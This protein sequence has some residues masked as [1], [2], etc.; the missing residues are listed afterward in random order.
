MRTNSLVLFKC[1]RR[2]HADHQFV[3]FTRVF[4]TFLIYMPPQ[5]DDNM[6]SLSAA[7][8]LDF[9]LLAQVLRLDQS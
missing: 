2:F 4:L 8:K 1:L 5:H 3:H 6:S 7:G 9:N